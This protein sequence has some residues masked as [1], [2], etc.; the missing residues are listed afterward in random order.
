MAGLV[1]R[2]AGDSESRANSSRRVRLPATLYIKRLCYP[3]LSNAGDHLCR[4]CKRVG[5]APAFLGWTSVRVGLEKGQKRGGGS[6]KWG[7]VCVTRT[8]GRKR[9]E[10]RR[11]KRRKKKGRK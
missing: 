1:F 3:S 4:G 8:D 10:G 5:K 2:V 6:V 9:K 7:N 11:R